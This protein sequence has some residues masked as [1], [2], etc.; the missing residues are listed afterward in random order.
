MQIFKSAIAKILLIYS[1]VW[2]FLSIVFAI[3]LLID[4]DNPLKALSIF[5]FLP[6]SVT[7]GPYMGITYPS[8]EIGYIISLVLS[9]LLAIVG[10]KNRKNIL[11]Q[12][13]AVIGML[14]RSFFGMLGLGTGT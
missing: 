5:L 2:V 8:F 3:Y 13:L 4:G 6:L 11:G 10:F 9:L 1:L 14:G 7:I 12:V